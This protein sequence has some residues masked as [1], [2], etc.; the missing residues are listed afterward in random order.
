M[1]CLLHKRTGLL[2]SPFPL[3]L[4]IVVSFLLSVLSSCCNVPIQRDDLRAEMGTTSIHA[5]EA[6]RISLQ[7]LQTNCRSH[8][9]FQPDAVP[10][11][12]GP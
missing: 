1:N 8:I 4:S 9:I 7:I 3:H 10:Q 5:S 12:L 11:Y 2:Y 6:P